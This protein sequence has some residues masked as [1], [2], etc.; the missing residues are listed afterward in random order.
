MSPTGWL[1]RALAGWAGR[2]RAAADQ[3]G[4][5]PAAAILFL[6]FSAAWSLRATVLFGV[7]DALLP[8]WP[9]SVWA[10]AVKLV[11]WT[12]PVLA[13]AFATRGR[14]ALAYLALATRPN[15]GWR[16]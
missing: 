6:A 13:Y 2:M 7:D 12:V 4:S 9:R 11:L 16:A 1:C 5:S 10:T 15:R 8:G 14:Q 3:R